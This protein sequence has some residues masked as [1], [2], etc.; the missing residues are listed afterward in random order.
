MTTAKSLSCA[1]TL[2][3]DWPSRFRTHNC[4]RT[5]ITDSHSQHPAQSTSYVVRQHATTQQRQLQKSPSNTQTES[6]SLLAVRTVISGPIQLQKSSS[7]S[8][9]KRYAGHQVL[10]RPAF[11]SRRLHHLRI[12]RVVD[13]S[14]FRLRFDPQEDSKRTLQ[15]IAAVVRSSQSGSEK[16]SKL[17]SSR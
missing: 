10:G 16:T 4:K 9:I 14:V 5:P 11:D 2:T 12:V 7:A 8:P 15:L 1:S 3:T 13:C 17:Q 6:G